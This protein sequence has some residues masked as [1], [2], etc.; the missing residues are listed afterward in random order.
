MSRKYMFDKGSLQIRIDGNIPSRGEGAQWTNTG[1]DPKISKFSGQE[2]TG[3]D[4]GVASTKKK[5]RAR[6]RACSKPA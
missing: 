6:A 1:L 4:Q 3:T 2:W 5:F